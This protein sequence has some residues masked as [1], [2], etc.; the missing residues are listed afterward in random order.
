MK[1]GRI[2]FALVFGL[3]GA[4]A[5]MI[6]FL[7]ISFAILFSAGGSFLVFSPLADNNYFSFIYTALLFGP[8]FIILISSLVIIL[9]NT[10]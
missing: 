2:V 9:R 1:I 4:I 7:V 3:L 6:A 10:K 5:Y 8:A